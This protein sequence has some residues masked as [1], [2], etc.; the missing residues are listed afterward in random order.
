MY[1]YA[2]GVLRNA[3]GCMK[4]L[5]HI[6]C[7]EPD[8]YCLTKEYQDE[9]EEFEDEDEDLPELLDNDNF[10]LSEIEHENRKILEENYYYDFCSG[11]YSDCTVTD[12]P[13]PKLCSCDDEYCTC[14]Y[15]EQ[16]SVTK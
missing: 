6:N 16:Y 5:F 10:P 14:A 9:F 15:I 8:C 13:R 11:F 12:N 7:E 1:H 4:D 3:A 2:A